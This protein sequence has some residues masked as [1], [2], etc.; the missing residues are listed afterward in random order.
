MRIT[1]SSALRLKYPEVHLMLSSVT[2][3]SEIECDTS[4]WCRDYMPVH[5]RD[6]RY[7]KFKY[8][9]PYLRAKKY[10][11][12]Q[13]DTEKLVMPTNMEI[14]HCSLILD[15]GSL[16]Q[17]KDQVIVSD[18]VLSWNR[19]ISDPISMIEC[20]FDKEVVV[21]PHVPGDFTQHMDGMFATVEG[22]TFLQMYDGLS[23]SWYKRFE[24][25]I[26]KVAVLQDIIETPYA[27]KN[28][29]GDY[30]AH[31][32]YVNWIETEDKL[33]VPTFGRE[34]LDTEKLSQIQQHVSKRCIGIPCEDLAME[35]GALHCVTWGKSD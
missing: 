9:P 32:C 30:T 12:E 23:S 7:V 16:V 2:E 34:G 1:V 15:G 24:G 5:I 10:Q 28:L 27:T 19:E 21:F 14:V 6:N 13:V 26:Q 25:A 8:T 11:L 18:A 3:L 22:K 29:N 31:G 33:L 17:T 4:V 35:G 20:L